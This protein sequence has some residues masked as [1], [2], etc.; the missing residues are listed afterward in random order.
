MRRMLLT[1]SGEPT[2]NVAAM[3]L[4]C[5]LRQGVLAGFKGDRNKQGCRIYFERVIKC[6]LKLVGK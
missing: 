5:R 1:G 4:F 2:R 6:R 3:L